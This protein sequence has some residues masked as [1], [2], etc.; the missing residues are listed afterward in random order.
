[1]TFVLSGSTAWFG[2]IPLDWKNLQNDLLRRI[3][4]QDFTV[5][6]TSS[7]SGGAGSRHHP[8]HE[9]FKWLHLEKGQDWKAEEKLLSPRPLEPW[10]HTDTQIHSHCTLHSDV[11]PFTTNTTV[12]TIMY[13]VCAHKVYIVGKAHVTI[14]LKPSWS[15]IQLCSVVLF[16]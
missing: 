13:I 4:R 15:W 14:N 8:K 12:Y 6:P 11:Q 9:L 10:T 1:M 2:N 5:L 3:H 16:F 7:N